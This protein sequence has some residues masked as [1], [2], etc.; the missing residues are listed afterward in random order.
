MNIL[1]YTIAG[2]ASVLLHAAFLFVVEEQKVFAMPAGNEPSSVSINF[3]S[4][5]AAVPPPVAEPVPEPKEVTKQVEQPKPTPPK[6]ASKP[7]EKKI[8][9]AKPVEKPKAKKVV[10]REPVKQ[11]VTPPKPKKTEQKTVKQK[12]EPKTEKKPVEKEPETQQPKTAASKGASSQPVLLDKPSFVSRPVQP[13]YP[14]LARKRGIEGVAMY[15]I[16]LDADGNQIKQVL[17]SSSGTTMLDKSAL[18]AI[19]QWKFSPHIS[20]GQKLAH[21]VQIPVRFKLD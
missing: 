6:K 15:E 21:R 13:R 3:V 9:K 8:V 17:I 4:M 20:G 7:V 14:R 5:P 18:D 12:P 19:K 11:N 2:S 1:R 16:W 10:K